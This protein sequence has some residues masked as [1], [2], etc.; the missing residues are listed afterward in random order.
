MNGDV[1]KTGNP[2]RAARD[3]QASGAREIMVH[4]DA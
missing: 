4:D 1:L 2:R 3:R